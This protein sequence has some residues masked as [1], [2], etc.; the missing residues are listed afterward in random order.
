MLKNSKNIV[1]ENF[2]ANKFKKYCVKKYKKYCV[3]QF[4]C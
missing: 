1:F 3:E 4:E 2:S